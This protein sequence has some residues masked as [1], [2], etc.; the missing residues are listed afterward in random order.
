[1]I[2]ISDTSNF[3]ISVFVLFVFAPH[4]AI[5]ILLERCSRSTD[6]KC[7]ESVPGER[8]N[9]IVQIRFNHD[10]SGE[11]DCLEMRL[12]LRCLVGIAR[13]MDEVVKV[14]MKTPVRNNSKAS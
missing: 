6:G 14:Q 2:S 8:P 9:E 7:A 11:F 3:L 1:M 4:S 13:E 10:G 5:G 12:P